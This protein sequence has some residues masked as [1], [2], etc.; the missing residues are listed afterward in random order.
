MFIRL[1][2]MFASLT[3]NKY[4]LLMNPLARSIEEILPPGVSDSPWCYIL[5]RTALVASSVCAAF[6]LPFFGTFW[7]LKLHPHALLSIPIIV[8]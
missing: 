7:T 6:I 8:F 1:L 3:F 4:A 2:L 5:L